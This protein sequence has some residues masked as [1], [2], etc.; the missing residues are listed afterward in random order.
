[1]KNVANAVGFQLL[2]FVCVLLGSW[3]AFFS[4]LVYLTFHAR[5]LQTKHKEFVLMFAFLVIGCVWDGLLIHFGVLIFP[6]ESLLLGTLPPVWLLCLW[7]S[8][9]TMLAHCL[10]FLVGRHLLAVCLGFISPV[11]S[12]IGGAKLSDAEIGAPYFGSVFIIA[13][14]WAV[15]L[16]LGFILCQKLQL[17]HE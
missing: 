5:Y 15:I 14:G 7:V 6:S 11:L 1:M 8:V 16:P 10:R 3:V 9:A 4:T 17:D 13:V 12:Y 2:W